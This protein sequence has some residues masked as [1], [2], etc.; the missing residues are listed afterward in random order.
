MSGHPNHVSVP[1]GASALIENLAQFSGNIPVRLFVLDTV[2]IFY[3]YSSILGTAWGKVKV[4]GYMLLSGFEILILDV[5]SKF[6]PDL[7]ET[8]YPRHIHAGGKTTFVSSYRQY[9]AAKCAMNAHK[10]QMVWFR[11][12]YVLFSQYMWVNTWTEVVA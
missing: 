9:L 4:Y 6:I 2:A 5:A 10:S 8:K 12:L 1:A 11:Q 7:L 3:K